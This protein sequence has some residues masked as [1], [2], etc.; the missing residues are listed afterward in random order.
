MVS[1]NGGDTTAD[2]SGGEAML[3]TFYSMAFTQPLPVSYLSTGGRGQWLD[4]NGTDASNSSSNANEPYLEFLEGL[5]D[6]DDE[7]LPKVVSI[8]YTDDEQSTPRAYALHVCDLF[9]QV[10]AR[11][12]S[13]LVASGDDGAYGVDRSDCAVNDGSGRSRFLATFPASC[14]YVTT[15]GATALYLPF[16]STSWSGGGFSEYFEAPAW[17]Q[18]DTAAYVDGLNGTH[19]GWFNPAGR[20]FPDLSLVGVRYLLGSGFTTKG[21]SAST[22]VW[23]AIVALINDARLRA[24]KSALGFLNPV[25]YSDKVRSALWDITSGNIG[26]CSLSNGTVEVGYSAAAGWDPASGLGTPDV[27]A[28][29]A[30]LG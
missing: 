10:A 4:E 20:G 15:V 8:S 28:L 27:G 16:E 6:M 3:D 30:I 22:P 2:G 5:L 26:G 14:P 23:A 24:G 1:L 18:A 17:Q 7:A 25:L 13:V 19:A 29:L 9:A 12:V 21:T 11:G